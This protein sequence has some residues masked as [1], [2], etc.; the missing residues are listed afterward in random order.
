ME[1]EHHHSDG[2]RAHLDAREP[3]RHAGDRSQH[4]AHQ[5]EHLEV[6]VDEPTGERAASPH[7]EPLQGA[8]Q[9]PAA[10]GELREEHV[11]DAEAADRQPL[12]ERAEIDDGMVLERRYAVTR[13]R[14][15]IAD[16]GTRCGDAAAPVQQAGWRPAPAQVRTCV[17]RT[18]RPGV[19]TGFPQRESPSI[20]PQS[21]PDAIIS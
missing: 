20:A 12:H 8:E 7:V 21:Q 11:D 19:A 1:L 3:H 13:D 18:N 16:H 9:Q 15:A 14:E 6:A 4:E 17:A 2:P 5:H 10:D